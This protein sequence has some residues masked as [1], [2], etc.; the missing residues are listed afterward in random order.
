M[1]LLRE[2]VVCFNNMQARILDARWVDLKT[3]MKTIHNKGHLD[4]FKIDGISPKFG[5]I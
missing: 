3:F 2:I 4:S 5:N 1:H